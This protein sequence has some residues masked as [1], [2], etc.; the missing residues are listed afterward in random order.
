MLRETSRD[1]ETQYETL[2]DIGDIDGQERDF[3]WH[4]ETF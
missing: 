2:N 3:E 4:L 1:N